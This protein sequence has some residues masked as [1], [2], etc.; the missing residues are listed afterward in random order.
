MKRIYFLAPTIESTAAIVDELKEH[1]ITDTQ[2]HVV[3]KDHHK[4]QE[5]HIHEANL[6]QTTD[7]VKS[8]EKGAIA[9][10]TVGILAGLAAVTFP[11][12]GVVLGG[13]AILGLGL[14]GTGFGAW[15]SSMIGISIPDRVV[16]KYEKAIEAGELL[17]MVDV[18][19]QDEEKFK[20]LIKSHHPEA[21]IEGAELPKE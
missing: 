21:E 13:G 19:K 16:E 14:F 5:A 9:G 18:P 4:L 2:I 1:G 3:G 17:M 12:A 10:G 8:L 15:V 6:L 7:L 20:K 11:P